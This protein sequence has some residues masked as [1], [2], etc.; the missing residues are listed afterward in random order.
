MLKR[1][2]R[3]IAVLTRRP[4][5]FAD[6]SVSTITWAGFRRLET[7]LK[8]T[9]IVEIIHCA[10]D[11]RFGIPLEEARAANVGRTRQL[12][13]F[14]RRCP[15]LG[16]FVHLS[17]VY[18]AGKLGGE[19]DEAPLPPPN[20]FFNVYQQSKY[21]AEE[22]VLGAMT[23]V[24]AAIFR[25]STIIGDS[26]G[27]VRQF[28][29]FHQLLK[30]I[31]NS[32]SV[33]VMPGDAVAQVDLIP[34]DWAVSVLD[35]LFEHRFQPGRI[36]H[37]CAG[38]RAAVPVRKLVEI[39]FRRFG[40]RPPRL[41]SLSEYEKFANSQR[42][43]PNGVV[44]EMLRILDQFL[45]Q[46]ALRQSFLNTRTAAEL[47]SAGLPVPDI[48]NYYERIIDYCIRT[49]WG[50]SSLAPA[51]RV[52]EPPQRERRHTHPVENLHNHPPDKGPGEAPSL[53]TP[54]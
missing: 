34:S 20:G 6:Q 33:P 46:L 23:S 40:L 13:D 9:N 15:R 42:S 11:I 8:P 31:P 50:R 2:H 5:L 16:K 38:P 45:P 22:L 4:E 26:C 52:I 43:A 44:G 27:E 19:F 41:V 10:A 30:M 47:D 36:Y 35:Y 3:K 18:A 21:E 17:S 48:D 12:L 49:G 29:Y 54:R 7:T 32:G 28:N 14:A 51:N 53:K 24:P 25:L 39:T 37:V 1:G